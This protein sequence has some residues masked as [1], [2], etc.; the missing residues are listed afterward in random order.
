MNGEFP[1]IYVAMVVIAFISWVFN[2]IQ[3]ATAERQRSQELKRR[4]QE[5]AQAP[6]RATSSAPPPLP[7]ERREEPPVPQVGE[8]LQELMEALGA[9]P[10]KTS[11]QP[12]PQ[13]PESAP[14][15]SPSK[16]TPPA[17]VEEP[18]LSADEREALARLQESARTGYEIPVARNRHAKRLAADDVRQSL[19]TPSGLKKAVLLKEVLD[20]PVGLR[21]GHGYGV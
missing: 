12:P 3:E 17:T 19:R 4:R 16:T 2:R 1:W 18:T 11:S 9:G 5:D 7:R 21:N 10:P 8:R 13:A 14:R 15:T 20:T 6:R